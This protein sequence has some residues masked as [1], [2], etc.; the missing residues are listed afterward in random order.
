[1]NINLSIWCL[2]NKLITF[3]IPK[4][5]IN[6]AALGNALVIGSPTKPAK[7]TTVSDFI[8]S[9]SKRFLFKISHKIK[10]FDKDY[11]GDGASMVVS[12]AMFSRLSAQK[13]VSNA[14]F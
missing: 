14:S 5:F 1:M 9:A 10:M 13:E 6:E 4:S 7:S 3:L 12:N 11:K 2:E 8:I